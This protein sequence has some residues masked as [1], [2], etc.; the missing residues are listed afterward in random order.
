[1]V[2][3]RLYLISKNNQSKFNKSVNVFEPTNKIT[4][5]IRYGTPV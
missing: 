5:V 1:M 2:D 4:Q 3:K